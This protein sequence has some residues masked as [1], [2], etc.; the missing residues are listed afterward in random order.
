MALEAFNFVWA[1]STEDFPTPTPSLSPRRRISATTFLWVG[2]GARSSDLPEHAVRVFPSLQVLNRVPPQFPHETFEHPRHR[3]PVRS[4]LGGGRICHLP[5]RTTALI[6]A[7]T[8]LVRHL[9]LRL[10]VATADDAEDNVFE[11]SKKTRFPGAN[12]IFATYYKS[13]CSVF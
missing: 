11:I 7:I 5:H 10:P 6:W 2:S 4:I 8:T 3:H 12:S 9:I 1:F 13:I